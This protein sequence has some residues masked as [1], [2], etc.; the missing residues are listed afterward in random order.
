MTVY[1]LSEARRNK[2]RMKSGHSEL[3]T[4]VEKLTEQLVDLR[5]DHDDLKK[6]VAKLLKSLKR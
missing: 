1:S 4:Q 2:T 6:L 5:K 3:H